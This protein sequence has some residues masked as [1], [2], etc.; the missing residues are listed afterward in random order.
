MQIITQTIIFPNNGGDTPGYLA[1]PI[2]NDSY[3]A[4]VA[5][6]EWWGLVPHIK[7]VVERLARQGYVALAPDLYHGQVAEEPDEAR[8]LAM[9]LDRQRAVAEITSAVYYLQS[10]S[11][12]APKKIGV[13]GWCMGGSLAISTAAQSAEIGAAVVFYGAPRDLSTVA[14]IRAPLLGLYG[15]NDHGIPAE[16]VHA[17]KTTLQKYGVPHEIHIYPGVGHAFFNDSRPHIYDPAAA[18]DAWQR[19]LAWFAKHLPPG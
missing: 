19:T 15:E 3:P 14:N 12:V 16:T 6:Q 8:K 1:R 17:L 2:G 18:Q 7:D 9:E 5:I 11:F 10:L 13:V 4:L